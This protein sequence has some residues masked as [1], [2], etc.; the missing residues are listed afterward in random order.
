MLLKAVLVWPRHL[1]L[2]VH[3]LEVEKLVPERILLLRLEVR[4]NSFDKQLSD[5]VNCVHD[6]NFLANWSYSVLNFILVFWKHE[7]RNLT[8]VQKVVE[9]LNERLCYLCLQT[10]PY[11]FILNLL[12]LYL[13]IL[14]KLSYLRLSSNISYIFQR[15]TLIGYWPWPYTQPSIMI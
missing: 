12:Y 11:I 15:P 1:F 14:D 9:I 5:V 10:L 2:G 8:G 3:F 4:S 7:V 6:F 13:Y